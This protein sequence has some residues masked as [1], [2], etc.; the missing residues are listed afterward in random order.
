MYRRNFLKTSGLLSLTPI[1]P[2][3]VNQLSRQIEPNDDH[4]ILVV[5]ELSGGNDGINTLVPHDDEE[6]RKLRPQLAI[7][8]SS[9]HT[10]D[11]SMGLHGAMAACKEL[12]DDG[13]LAIVNGVGY[14]NP[15]RSHFE[16]MAIWHQGMCQKKRES[17]AGW[18]GQAMDLSRQAGQTS[19]DGYFVGRDSIPEAMTGRRAQVAA[20]S[21]L[22]DLRLDHSIRALDQP[23]ER[24]DITAFVQRQVTDSYQ[25]AQ[26][27]EAEIKNST[28]DGF[29]NSR[30]GQQMQLISRLIKSKSAAKVYYTRQGGYDTHATQLRQHANLLEELATSMKAFHDDM[31]HHGLNDR[32]VVM[33]FSEFGRRVAENGTLGTDHGTAGPVFLSGSPIRGGLLG[34]RT[35]LSDLQDGD[36]R[37]QF[38]FRRIY[39]SL[40]DNWLEIDSGS[41][42]LNKFEHLELF[43]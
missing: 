8:T 2:G 15:N 3:F 13:Q 11:D 35:D 9:L 12:F 6:Y 37:M 27:M 4:R 33:A 21:R 30:L 39:A 41:V 14:P 42:V 23:D 16:S 5:I 20:L 7:E 40:L 18:L 36:L 19:M 25:M 1:V 26:Q 32:I 22:E 24:E 28:T 10:I 29:P 43:K 38:D 31:D 17:G 34:N